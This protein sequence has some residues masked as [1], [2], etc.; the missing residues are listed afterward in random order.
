MLI[1]PAAIAALQTSFST[2]FRDAYSDSP[3]WH[4]QLAT[5]VPSSNRTNT[6]GWMQ[7][8]PRMREWLGPRILQ[9]VSA[10]SYTLANLPYEL[11]VAVDRDDFEDANLGTYAPLMSEMGRQARKWP[12]E[13]CRNALQAGATTG[14]GF[15]GLSFFNVAHPIDPAG[16]QSNLFAATP[17]TPVNYGDVRE[18]MMSYTGEDGLPLGVMP[19]C[20]IVPP[21]LERQAREILNS[22]IIADPGGVNAGVSNVLQGS[23]KLLVVP[24]LANEPARWYLADTSKA[25]KPLIFQLRKAPELVAKTGPTEDNTFFDKQLIWG[26]SSRGAVGYGL[27]FLCSRCN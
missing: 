1:T 2:R 14:I 18:A 24:E 5:V 6:Y 4:D 27:F 3:I 10:S 8:L 15:D 25:I 22:T 16:V 13:L 17:L 23:A 20:L 19:D 9:N 21:Q 11:T 12:D 26:V 7:R